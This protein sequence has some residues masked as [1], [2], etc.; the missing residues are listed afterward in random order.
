MRR[1]IVVLL[2]LIANAL[3]GTN[4]VKT[5]PEVHPVTELAQASGVLVWIATAQPRDF[6]EPEKRQDLLDAKDAIQERF[7]PRA[8]DFW[9]DLA[10]PDGTMK[11]SYNSGD[12]THFNDAGHAVLVQLVVSCAIPEVISSSG[13]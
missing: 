12:G 13:Q 7:A 10:N 8:I 5:A 3:F 11:S 2:L 1:A 4:K 6:A 9:S